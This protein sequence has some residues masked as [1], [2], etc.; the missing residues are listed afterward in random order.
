[1]IVFSVDT[2]A[3]RA[4]LSAARSRAAAERRVAASAEVARLESEHE[5]MI[6]RERVRAAAAMEARKTR[7]L[8]D[9]DVSMKVGDAYNTT[10]LC[11]RE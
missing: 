1:M 7:L 9:A 6:E 11:R 3:K 4:A 10:A 5:A 2:R 8:A